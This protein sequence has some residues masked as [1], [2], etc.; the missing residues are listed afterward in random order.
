VAACHQR[1]R[2]RF[3]FA[4]TSVTGEADDITLAAGRLVSG[5]F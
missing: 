3:A 4:N 2:V 5:S 1:R